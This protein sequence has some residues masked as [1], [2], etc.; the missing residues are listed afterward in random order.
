MTPSSSPWVGPNTY[1]KVAAFSTPG[2]A[3]LVSAPG[4]AKTDDALGSAGYSSGDYING[5]G[6]SYAAPYVSGVIALMLQANP[7]LGYRDVMEILAY[8]AKNSDP[9]ST[10]WQTQRRAR[11]ER[12]RP[13]FLPRLRIRHGRCDGGV[14]ARRKLDHQST[15]ADMSRRRSATPT[16]PRF[17]TGPAVCRARSRSALPKRLDK[18]VVDINITH[19]HVSDLTVTLTSPTRHDRGAGFAPRERSRKRHRVRRPLPTTSG[20]EDA[21][22]NWTL[23]VTDAA[24][25]G[26]SGTIN[27][28]TLQ[29]LGDAA[30]TPTT[31]VYTDEFATRGR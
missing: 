20:G 1:G 5:S 11:L 4:T 3:L 18:V 28:W 19:S 7:N 17:R 15:Y 9:T 14:R 2:A 27:G 29:A 6:T 10:G 8:S 13:A 24:I 12:R 22:G 30:N 31:Y 25:S 21:Q 26:N 16:T 23:T